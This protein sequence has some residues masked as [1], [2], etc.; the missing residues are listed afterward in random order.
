MTG[1]LNH[2]RLV[3]VVECAHVHAAVDGNVRLDH[4]RHG[5]IDDTLQGTVAWE[6]DNEKGEN[7]EYGEEVD[8]D[9]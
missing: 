7:S 4:W 9:C 1:T 5:A 6:K 8:H 2:L 3:I